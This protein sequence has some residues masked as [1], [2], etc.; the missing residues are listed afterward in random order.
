MSLNLRL[1]RYVNSV[2]HLGDSDAQRLVPVPAHHRLLEDGG[3]CHI[4]PL[5]DVDE[6]HNGR[7]VH[8]GLE[9]TDT[10]AVGNGR[11]S[12]G[13]DAISLMGGKR[14]EKTNASEGLS[15]D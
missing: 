10:E 14:G 1:S 8:K 13:F 11:H 12:T 3:A 7:V 15:S 5:S 6:G 9:A 2:S 4:A